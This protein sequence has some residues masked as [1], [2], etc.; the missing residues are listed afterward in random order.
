MDTRMG[1]LPNDSQG[2]HLFFIH[3]LIGIL[4]LPITTQNA[5]G[6]LPGVPVPMAQRE[7]GGGG[8]R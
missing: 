3:R 8:G 5:R 4:K 6:L 7:G 2:S 1:F